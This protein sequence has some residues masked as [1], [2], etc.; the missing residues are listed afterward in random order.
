MNNA[1]DTIWQKIENGILI[2]AEAGKNFIQTE[3]DRP[4]REYL[5]NA[6][7]FVLAAKE[8]GADAV[9]FQTH[10]VDDEIFKLDFTSPHFSKDRLSWVT[11][12]TQ[13]TPL[14]FWQELKSYCESLDIV[15]FSTPMSRGAAEKLARVGVNL[16]KIGS[17]DILDFVMLDYLRNSG[18]PIILSSGMSTL[19]ELENAVRFLKEKNNRVA[20]LHCVSKYPCPVKDLHLGTIQFLKNKYNIPVGFSDHSLSL[21]SAALAVALGATII[22]KHFS[23]GRELYGAD[24]KVSLLPHEFAKMVNGIRLIED[25]EEKKQEV[26]ARYNVDQF[27][28]NEHKVL[29]DGEAVFRPIFRKSL[30]V[31]QN[32]AAGTVLRPEHLYAMRPQSLIGGLPS[33]KYEEVVGKT[34]K[35]SLKKYEGITL[36]VLS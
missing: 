8:A 10:N 12:N 4:V 15:F 28:G 30:V 25:S 26:L 14:E 24:H 11:R 31:S 16:W 3:G 32:V 9:K 33:E 5:E 7:K 2:I 34:L 19:E 6:K 35:K 20:L 22:E 23:F 29:Q 18:K 17:G 36:D 21:D 13:A 1:S 27:L